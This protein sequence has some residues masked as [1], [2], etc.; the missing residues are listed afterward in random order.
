MNNFIKKEPGISSIKKKKVKKLLQKKER[1]RIVEASII[2]GKEKAQVKAKI[3]K[4][5]KTAT[6]QMNN[7]EELRKALKYLGEFKIVKDINL[8]TMIIGCIEYIREVGPQM[9]AQDLRAYKQ[10]FVKMIHA[11]HRSQKEIQDYQKMMKDQKRMIAEKQ[12]LNAIEDAIINFVILHINEIEIKDGDIVDS[13][14]WCDKIIEYFR[15]LKVSFKY[16]ELD[17]IISKIVL[18]KE[19]TDKKDANNSTAF[20]KSK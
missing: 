8:Q 13:F 14:Y 1:N 17:A 3:A 9:R 18:L 2:K 19:I 15:D 7:E 16:E 12:R 20:V 5:R 4:Q 11:Y 10:A 6:A